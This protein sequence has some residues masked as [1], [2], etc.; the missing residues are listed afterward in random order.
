MVAIVTYLANC[1]PDEEN[2]RKHNAPIFHGGTPLSKNALAN[3]AEDLRHTF[4][5][6]YRR[7]SRPVPMMRPEY[8]VVVVGSGY[9]GA[10]AACR[11]ARAGKSVC[12][13]ELGKE[14]WPGEY[15]VDFVSAAPEIHVSGK[16]KNDSKLGEFDIGDCQGLY[17]L[18]VGEGQNA[19]VANGKYLWGPSLIFPGLGGT[20]LL[21]ANVF[22]QADHRTLS[23]G[24]FPP[25]IRDDPSCLDK[26][27]I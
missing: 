6:K 13:L 17:H 18:I 27:M 24:V 21:N 26:C 8:D 22:L 3:E 20:S 7:I 15:P 25:E 14:R 10:V 4:P 11:M 1:A 9:G 5:E 12:L 16:I 2:T 19:F 23:Q